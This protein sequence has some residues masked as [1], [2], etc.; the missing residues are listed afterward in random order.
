MDY[1]HR[2]EN[3]ADK[4][5]GGILYSVVSLA[6]IAGK[7]AEIFPVMNLGMD[8]YENV[9]SF[10]GRFE[11]IQTKY[12]CKSKHK[13]RVVNLFYDDKNSVMNTAPGSYDREESSTEPTLPVEYFQ[14]KDI[15][16]EIDGILVN[17]VSG[18]DLTIDTFKK[19]RENFSGY[20]HMDLHNLV[21]QTFPDGT[22]VRFPL[23]NW[24]QWCI[25]D[26]LQMNEAEIAVLTGDNVT[27]YEVAE[28]I[29]SSGIVNCIVVTR[30]IQGVSLYQIKDSHLN[31]ADIKAISNPNFIDSTGCG[32]VFAS[33]FFY[34]NVK[35]KSK[36]I[37]ASMKFANEM[38]SLNTSL[39]GV[40][41]LYKLNG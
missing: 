23:K 34:N 13:T 4:Q 8:E 22:R 28:R 9:V 18:V 37:E 7:E 2:G 11:N 30:G 41:N 12:I 6:V 39:D 19:I 25:A 29:L 38:A 17:M 5:F 40:E 27:E 16:N 36:D 24:N 3:R 1:I 14:I 10:L 33:G 21:M 35:N 31:R 26:T 20:I 15:L 32:D